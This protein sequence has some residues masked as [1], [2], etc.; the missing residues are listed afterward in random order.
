MSR[1]DNFSRFIWNNA[2]RKGD[3]RGRVKVAFAAFV[4]S[5]DFPCI[6]AKAAINSGSETVSVFDRLSSTVA[7]ELLAQ[8]L[9]TFVHSGIGYDYATYV[10]IFRQPRALHEQE[11]ERLLWSQLR[12]LHRI[13]SRKHKWDPS[14]ASDP[15]NPRF[16]FSFAGKALY[17]VGLHAGSSRLSRQFPWPTLVFN[18]H[19]QFERIR[20][21]GKWKQMQKTIRTRDTALQGDINPML[22]DFGEQ[23]EARQ[24]SGRIVAE[25]WRAPFPGTADLTKPRCPFRR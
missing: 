4:Q 8:E 17:V 6:G 15:S 23:S 3:C 21:H 13:D 9:E 1:E 12:R 18:L 20:H 25:E 22:S 5:P 14:V 11:F 19:E 24:Y 10:A 16:S 7:T 2:A